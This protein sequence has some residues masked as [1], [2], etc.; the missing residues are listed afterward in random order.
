VVAKYNYHFEV[1]AFYAFPG[2]AAGTVPLYRTLNYQSQH[3]LYTTDEDERDVS[4]IN[5]ATD[6]GIACYV[7]PA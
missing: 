3:H 2:Q 1:I 7:Y 6:E 4:I 5:G